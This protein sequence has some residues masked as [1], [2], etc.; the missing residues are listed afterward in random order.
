MGQFLTCC[1]IPCTQNLPL[2]GIP[3]CCM[4]ISTF[5]RP[6]FLDLWSLLYF[7]Q[8]CAQTWR[9]ASC[10]WV[11]SYDSIPPFFFFK[12]GSV[13]RVN[14][15]WKCPLRHWM[16]CCVCLLPLHKTE[17]L[18]THF[19]EGTP[20]RESS[21]FRPCCNGSRL[22]SSNVDGLVCVLYIFEEIAVDEHMHRAFIFDKDPVWVQSYGVIVHVVRDLAKARA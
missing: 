13:C 20:L 21:G 11:C 19:C 4:R 3:P 22:H 8:H 6:G 18:L 2:M 10:C 17:Y 15:H 16:L 7:I 1:Y 5:L 9:H 12:N 14:G